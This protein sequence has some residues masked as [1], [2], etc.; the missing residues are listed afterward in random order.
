MQRILFITLIISSLIT[1]TAE[2][3]SSTQLVLQF[4]NELELTF[5]KPFLHRFNTL[6]TLASQNKSPKPLTVAFDKQMTPELGIVLQTLITKSSTEVAAFN[7][8][9]NYSDTL[10][11]A[12][13]MLDIRI[14][15]NRRADATLA[16]FH[17]AFLQAIIREDAVKNWCAQARSKLIETKKIPTSY[18]HSPLNKVLLLMEVALHSDGMEL[19]TLIH[20]TAYNTGFMHTLYTYMYGRLAPILKQRPLQ[21]TT[22]DIRSHEYVTSVRDALFKSGAW[23]CYAALHGIFKSEEYDALLYGDTNLLFPTCHYHLALHDNTQESR[24][25]YDHAGKPLMP[26]EITTRHVK[27]PY[28]DSLHFKQMQTI[29]PGNKQPVFFTHFDAVLLQEII[30]L[31]KTSCLYYDLS[32]ENREVYVAPQALSAF[33]TFPSAIRINL[34]TISPNNA[35]TIEKH[36]LACK[37]TSNITSEPYSGTEYK[38]FHR[39]NSSSGIHKAIKLEKPVTTIIFL[40]KDGKRGAQLTYATIDDTINCTCE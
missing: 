3:A 30:K 37:H 35:E 11:D 28:S 1:Q 4:S 31:K 20:E 26:Y 29:A 14:Q 22:C 15:K 2:E 19:G 27:N 33:A 40:D 38:Q 18:E 9:G 21:K 5:E 34:G 6:R 16:P 39:H 32:G 17:K 23:H 13:H 25:E 24:Y 7:K 10:F 12:M 8:R 36:V